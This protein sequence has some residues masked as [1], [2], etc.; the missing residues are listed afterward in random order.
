MCTSELTI[1]HVEAAYAES[2]RR[3][4]Y[5]PEG[6]WNILTNKLEGYIGTLHHMWKAIS[7]TVTA[8]ELS[9]RRGIQEGE[10]RC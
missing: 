5:L 1:R 2:L 9:Y 7:K 10:E 8:A 4:P 3:H 6:V